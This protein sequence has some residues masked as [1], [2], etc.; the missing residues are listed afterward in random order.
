MSF[1]SKDYPEAKERFI[2]AARMA[3]AK[4]DQLTLQSV[5][6][7]G[8]ALTVDTAIL[9]DLS[10]SKILLHTSGIH[11]VEGFAGSAIQLA[12]LS[13]NIPKPSDVSLVFVHILNPYGMAWSRRVNENNVDLNRNFLGPGESYNGCHPIYK[14]LD[15]FLNPS[16]AQ[17][18]FWPQLVYNLGRVGFTALKDAIVQ[19]QYDFRNGLFFGGQDLEEGP[20]LYKNWLKKNVKAP[21]VVLALDVHTG[22]GRFGEEVLFCHTNHRPPNIGK[23]FTALS[24]PIGYKVRGGLESL[25]HEVFPNSQWVHFTQ[26]FGTYSMPKI[27]RVLREENFHFCRERKIGAS[28]IELKKIMNPE[29]QR[30]QHHVVEQGVETLKRSIEWLAAQ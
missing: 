4:L 28:E 27:L 15:P 30:W 14:K 9:G 16:R 17:T 20:A 12:A 3:E 25:T 11:G 18:W 5:G 22:L 26:E 1:F 7:S 10:S 8:E 2:A 29:D 23:K 21:K 24:E 13:K 19:G 6:L